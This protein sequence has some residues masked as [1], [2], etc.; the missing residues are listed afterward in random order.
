MTGQVDA[1]AGYQGVSV[2]NGGKCPEDTI[3]YV[4]AKAQDGYALTG[5]QIN[6][7]T[8]VSFDPCE[9]KILNFNFPSQDTTVAFTTQQVSSDIS[10]Q[11]NDNK[12]GSV[13]ATVGGTRPLRATA[14]VTDVPFPYTRC[15]QKSETC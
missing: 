7:D 5:Y 6:G 12:M 4:S 14:T 2:K 13:T 3:V 15:R 8:A 10:F 9:T 11:P 1:S